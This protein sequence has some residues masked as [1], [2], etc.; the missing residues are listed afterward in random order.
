VCTT[1]T[2]S[3][4]GKEVSFPLC[5]FCGKKPETLKPVLAR[6]VIQGCTN[7]GEVVEYPLCPYC[8]NKPSFSE[9]E[10]TRKCINRTCS[11]YD[12]IV[13]NQFPLCPYCGSE[14]CLL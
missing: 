11:N 14:P 4:K 2:C 6:C 8:G 10:K 5:P 13:P 1:P 3:N 7:K 12:K 9:P